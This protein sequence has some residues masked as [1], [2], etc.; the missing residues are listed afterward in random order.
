MKIMVKIMRQSLPAKDLKK[1][2]L[3]SQ[4]HVKLQRIL[5]K[6]YGKILT[7]NL[8]YV[9]RL[10]FNWNKMVKIMVKP[11]NCQRRMIG[12]THSKNCLSLIMVSLMSTQLKKW[13]F[14][15][16]IRMKWQQKGQTLWLRTVLFQELSKI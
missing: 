16:D 8:A 9:K 1:K 13:I 7:I 12:N 6:K 2:D 10:K 4:I 11:L 5:L 3:Q 15:K 14:Q